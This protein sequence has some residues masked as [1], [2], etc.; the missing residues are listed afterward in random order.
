MLLNVIT[1]KIISAAF[2]LKVKLNEDQNSSTSYINIVCT[3][4][5]SQTKWPIVML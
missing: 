3:I 4:A 1:E 5:K 2:Q